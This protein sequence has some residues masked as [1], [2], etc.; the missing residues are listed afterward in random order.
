MF[1]MPSR[2][3]SPAQRWGIAY[4]FVAVFLLI[5]FKQGLDT[6]A[7]VVVFFPILAGG[8]IGPGLVHLAGYI[9]KSEWDGI[10]LAVITF[11]ACA[12]VTLV[13]GMVFRMF[14]A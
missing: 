10:P 7:F 9:L 14:L 3:S 11:V 13:L 8:V 5:K 12:V 1:F 4:L 6:G 2:E